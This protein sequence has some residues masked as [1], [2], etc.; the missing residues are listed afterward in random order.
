MDEVSGKWERAH[1][2]SP[3]N[4]RVIMDKQEPVSMS[5]HTHGAH[6]DKVDHVCVLQV[7]YTR[8]R[9]SSY[10]PKFAPSIAIVCHRHQGRIDHNG[11]TL[12]CQPSLTFGVLVFP[13]PLH[14]RPQIPQ[15][16]RCDGCPVVPSWMQG[17]QHST[18]QKCHTMVE[19]TSFAT[20]N[21]LDLPTTL[22]TFKA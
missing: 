8:T 2:F 15:Y 21:T 11:P 7:M 13:P 10:L 12:I 22:G 1:V 3:I 14:H 5:F 20:M 17:S 18:D 6:H 4:M 19:E 9:F 16:C